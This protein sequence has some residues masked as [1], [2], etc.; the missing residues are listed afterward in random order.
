M[1]YVGTTSGCG[2]SCD[3]FRLVPMG[4]RFQVVVLSE[5]PNSTGCHLYRIAPGDNFELVA[6]SKVSGGGGEICH[7][8]GA[9]GPPIGPQAD[10][11]YEN[12]TPLGQLGSQCQAGY[13]ACPGDVGNVTFA[14]NADLP[15]QS[16][17]VGRFSIHHVAPITCRDFKSCVDVYDVRVER[18][19]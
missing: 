4:T 19:P 6:G 2:S 5:N 7:F 9:A 3:D 18:L 8:T 1:L 13:A 11:D 16:P 17:T 14:L 10:F 12:C 15:D